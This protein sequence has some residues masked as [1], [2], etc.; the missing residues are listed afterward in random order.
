MT[1][2][3]NPYVAAYREDKRHQARLDKLLLSKYSTLVGSFRMFSIPPLSVQW[4]FERL[5]EF[6]ELIAKDQIK[7]GKNISL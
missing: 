7:Q 1:A 4:A 3:E 2:Y 6:Q 5:I